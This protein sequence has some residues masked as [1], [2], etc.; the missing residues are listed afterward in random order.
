MVNVIRFRR[1]LVIPFMLLVAVSVSG[2][3]AEQKQEFDSGIVESVFRYQIS[4]C[5]EN[6]TISVFLL[7]VH[8]I[9]PDCEK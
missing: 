3:S 6:M 1:F 4:Q 5:A 7:S 9:D 8:G 2:Q